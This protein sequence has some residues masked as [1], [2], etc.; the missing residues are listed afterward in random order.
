MTA[1]LAVR[2]A[3]DADVPAVTALVNAA[4]AV[5]RAFVDRDRTSADE[6][7]SMMAKGTFFVAD[8]TDGSMLAAMY[9]ERRAAHVYLGMLSIQP[10]Q[11]GRGVGRAM[12]SA[13][14][15]QCRAWG[16]TALDIRILHLRTELPP[17]YLKLGF[18]ETGRTEF[19]E[20]PLSREPYYF[21]LMSKSI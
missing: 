4:F 13:A 19:V 6:I 9:L 18:I 1:T 12:M 5:E 15:T 8:H 20:D 16:C 7:R 11:Q 14:E 10:S 17:F 3:T 2:A 21:I